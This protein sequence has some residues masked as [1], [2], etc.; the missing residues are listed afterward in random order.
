MAEIVE[1][2]GRHFLQGDD[3][4]I[5]GEMFEAEDGAH[6]VV[7]V[8]T[9]TILGAADP[10]T[11]Q[12]VDHSRYELDTAA[13]AHQ[14]NPDVVE[15]RAL[16]AQLE[17]FE[18]QRAAAG[19]RDQ[20]E[21]RQRQFVATTDDAVQQLDALERRLGRTLLASEVEHMATYTGTSIDNGRRMDLNE[22]FERAQ[23]DRPSHARTWA[24]DDATDDE[25]R[26][27]RQRS[28]LERFEESR[29]VAHGREATAPRE[30]RTSYDVS[31]HEDR[32]QL[33]ADRVEGLISPEQAQLVR[34]DS[35][36]DS[37]DAAEEL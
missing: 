28:A 19:A 7:D 12:A 5:L 34:Y 15:A 11:G 30:A 10:S 3:G 33:I 2:D 36:D 4:N 22:A 8:D 9:G 35:R 13:P 6:V 37:R 25:R 14:P 18:A 17:Q 1:W 27:A 24:G 21:A 32:A 26:G 29:N 16:L 20:A 23:A 31:R